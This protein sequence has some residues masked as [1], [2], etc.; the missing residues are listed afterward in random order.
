VCT[1]SAD[2]CTAFPHHRPSECTST[3]LKYFLLLK[4]LY[5]YL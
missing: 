5:K 1:T 3:V 2:P 4:G